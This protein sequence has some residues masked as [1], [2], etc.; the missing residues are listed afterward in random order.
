MCV[1]TELIYFSR[2]MVNKCCLSTAKVL[3]LEIKFYS[4]PLMLE[5]WCLLISTQRIFHYISLFIT[6]TFPLSRFISFSCWIIKLYSF[7]YLFLPFTCTVIWRK[8][9]LIALSIYYFFF[10]LLLVTWCSSF[11]YQAAKFYCLQLFH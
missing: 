10:V 11:Y 6:F 5:Q 7:L 8:L 4:H 1:S 2:I 9:L 3:R